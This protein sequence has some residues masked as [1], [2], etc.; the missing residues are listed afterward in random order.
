[1]FD[2]VTIGT[3]TRDVFLRS[4][5]FKVLRDPDHLKKIG[6]VSGEA[7]CFALGSK[8]EVGKPVFATGGGA[9]N[10]AVT[11]RKQGFS[12]AAVG[13]VGDDDSGAAVLNDL[14]KEGIRPFLSVDK[15]EGTGHSTVLLTEGG[16]RTILVYRGAAEKLVKRDIPFSKLKTKW[17]YIAPGKMPATVLEEVALHFKKQGASIAINPSRFYLEHEG[18]RLRK[19]LKFF[20]VVFVNREEASY[21]TGVPYEHE[22]KIF[23]KFDELIKG[24]AVVT[25]GARGAKVSDGRY[26]Y[27]AGIFKEKKLV[28]RTGAGDAFASGFVA[29]LIQKQDVT[30]ALRL[31][32][33]NATANVEAIGAHGGVLSKNDFKNRRWNYLDLGVEPL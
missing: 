26:L 14:K 23:K 20:D 15:N 4:P 22:R 21:L 28:D 16:E 31:A 11:F 30:Y 33:A 29:G 13:K 24:I 5:L 25:D 17:V 27:S 7:E 2:V 12:V 1:M 18:E 3:A 6:F 9:I 19:M 32:S 8:L 10:A